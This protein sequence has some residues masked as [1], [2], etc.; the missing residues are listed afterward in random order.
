[1]NVVKLIPYYFLGQLSTGNLNVSLAL[2][3]VAIAG[4]LIGIFLIR[5][6]SADLFYKIAY[7]LIFLLSLKLI[8]DGIVGIFFA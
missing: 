3:P 7:I 2:A 4:M 6:I 8:Y 5:R 1:V